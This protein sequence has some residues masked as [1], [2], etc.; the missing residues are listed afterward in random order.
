MSYAMADAARSFIDRI[1][2]G[3]A[4]GWRRAAVI[5]LGAGARCD[6]EM[7][8][9]ARRPARVRTRIWTVT[10]GVRPTATA[11]PDQAARAGCLDDRDVGGL[12]LE[13]LFPTR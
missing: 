6:L 7:S 5:A 10:A 1:R 11:R 12:G 3:V 2:S 4:S 9:G 8:D 13:V